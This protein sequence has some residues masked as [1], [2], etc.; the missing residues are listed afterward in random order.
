M[1]RGAFF[2]VQGETGL[3]FTRQLSQTQIRFFVN[4]VTLE[5]KVL[6]IQ[7]PTH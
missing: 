3:N 2:S 6:L 7:V 4:Q 5:N 1:T